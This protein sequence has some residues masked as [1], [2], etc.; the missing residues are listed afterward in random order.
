M[1]VKNK[2]ELIIVN[3]KTEPEKFESLMQRIMKAGGIDD[4]VLMVAIPSV[5]VDASRYIA[6][7]GVINIFAGLERGT[8]G[9]IDPALI[10]GPKQIRWIS[11]SGSG[12][13]DQ[14]EVV[15]KAI[16]KKLKP[17]FSV[18]AVGGFYQIQDGLKA[19]KNFTFPGKIVIYPQILNFPL[20]ALKDLKEK[21]PQ[22]Y[23][24]LGE[25]HTWTFEAEKQFI[26]SE[27][28]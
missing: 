27:L 3:S 16:E 8:I 13:E 24:A 25:G 2:K 7:N 23:A 21:V 15:K 5:V 6:T 22:A 18:A 26:E 14:K 11:H 20:T 17:E 19:M 28:K 9:Q 10:Y 4:I 12:L 1:A